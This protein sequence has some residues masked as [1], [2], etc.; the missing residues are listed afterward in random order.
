MKII[1]HRGYAGKYPGLS[2]PAY[3]AAFELPIHG[4]ETD[5]RLTKDGHVVCFHDPVATLGDGGV[6]R[7][8][9]CTLNELR[10]VDLGDDDDRP[11]Q[12]MTLHEL[13]EMAASY[14]DKHLYI[15][16]KHPMRY[17]RMLEEAV[18]NVLGY[19]G[20]TESPRIDV[21][22]FSFEAISRMSKLAPKIGR[23][24]L[25]RPFLKYFYPLDPRWGHP[26]SMG[27][28]LARAQL[29]PKLIGAKGLPTYLW[30][31]NDADDMAWAYHQGVEMLV[32][33]EPELALQVLGEAGGSA[34][35]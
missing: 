18:R 8:S 4:V 17:G 27:L 26:H 33:D 1:A 12:L 16:L 15:E 5:V 31:V 29:H 23:I 7:T 13:L 14:P 35:E 28:S 24:V 20:L 3:E 2:R 34:S 30:T 32:T 19:H 10:T 22:S 6:S 25:R 9:S 11:Q 21:I